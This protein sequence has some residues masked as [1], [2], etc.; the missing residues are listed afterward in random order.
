MKIHKETLNRHKLT[1]LQLAAQKAIDTGNTIIDIQMFRDNINHHNNWQKLRYHGL[2]WH[3][4]EH[5]QIKRGKWIITTNGWRFLRGEL[6]L[7]KWVAIGENH[8]VDKSTQLVGLRNLWHAPEEVIS[9]FQYY[10]DN[11]RYV[12]FKPTV[13]Q[14]MQASLL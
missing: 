1:M 12:G 8:I 11:G 6:E 13:P 5:G 9:T 14:N 10:D 7:P 3:Y 2:I 4:Q